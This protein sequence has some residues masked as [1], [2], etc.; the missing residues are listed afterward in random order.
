MWHVPFFTEV[1]PRKAQELE[2]GFPR[3]RR[4]RTL[5][6]AIDGA[7]TALCPWLPLLTAT[8]TDFDVAEAL[9]EPGA[10][11]VAEQV[12]R[13]PTAN[14]P[15]AN[16]VDFFCYKMNGDVVRHHPG[17]SEAQNM[18]PHCMPFGSL[19]FHMAEAAQQEAAEAARSAGVLIEP[20]KKTSVGNS[21]EP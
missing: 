8:F 18:Q 12:V 14:R 10:I 17:R 2:D 3:H 9:G 13:V 4:Y 7:S 15:P 16:R 6:E 21:I 11:V 19:R 5:R 20:Y 1:L